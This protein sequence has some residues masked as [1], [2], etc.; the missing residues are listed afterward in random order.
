MI[1]LGIA[2]IIWTLINIFDGT[3]VRFEHF[4]LAPLSD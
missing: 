4:P 1:V 3:L 2:F